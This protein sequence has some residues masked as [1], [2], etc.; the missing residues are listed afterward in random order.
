M[1]LNLDT[2]PLPDKKYDYVVLL[3]VL[4]YLY[5]PEN[6]AK[7]ACAAAPNVVCSY[8]CRPENAS[9]AD[10]ADQRSSMGWVNEFTRN[11][12]VALFGANGFAVQSSRIYNKTK[13][14]EQ[15]LMHFQKTASL[16]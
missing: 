10:V 14:F 9:T 7:K 13:S 12:L 8:C 6:A 16:T 2:D 15:V 4:E 3:G 5:E 1:I 11:E